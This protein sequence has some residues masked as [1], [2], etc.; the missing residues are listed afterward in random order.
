MLEKNDQKSNLDSTPIIRS[1]LRYILIINGR[2]IHFVAD[3]AQNKVLVLLLVVSGVPAR[4]PV[5][6]TS[7]STCLGEQGLSRSL[8]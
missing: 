3:Q 7:T 4:N 5:P 2:L 8:N 6:V 1:K